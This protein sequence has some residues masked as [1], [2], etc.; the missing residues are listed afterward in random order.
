MVGKYIAVTHRIVDPTTGAGIWFSGNATG[1]VALQSYEI[2]AEKAFSALR[3]SLTFNPQ[4]Q[5][6]LTP[7]PGAPGLYYAVSA[8]DNGSNFPVV[9]DQMADFCIRNGC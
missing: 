1:F 7:I 4:W 2:Q 5:A 3:G 9:E 8:P 6:E